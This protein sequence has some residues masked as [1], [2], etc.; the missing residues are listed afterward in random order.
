MLTEIEFSKE[1]AKRLIEKVEGLTIFSINSLE[2]QTEYENSNEFKHFL[3]NCYSEYLREPQEIENIFP[4]YLNSAES[5]YKQ[6]GDIKITDILPVVKD[7]RF[8]NSIEEINPDFELNHIYEQYN[9]ELY[10]FY[11][12]DT[13]TSI[14]YLTKNDFENLN[15][16]RKELQKIAIEN[17][18]N[19]VEI[20]KH[21]E[22]GYYMLVADGNYESSL[23]LL[24]IWNAENFEVKGKIV[25]GIPSRD[26]L[27]VTGKN[28]LENIERLAKTID[29]INESGD[30]LVSKKMFEYNNGRFD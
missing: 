10:V 26:V 9:N 20:E 7:K 23:I 13:E 14:H 16:D 25:I 27:L 17:L 12:E 24:D 2:I 19:S 8:L 11:V 28:D 5:L 6:N 21:G 3:Y 22:D 4:K 18:S 15:I 29:E 1:F 30:H